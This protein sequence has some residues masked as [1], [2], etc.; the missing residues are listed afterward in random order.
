MLG[1][2]NITKPLRSLGKSDR[3]ERSVVSPPSS[4]SSL[5]SNTSLGSVLPI[6]LLPLS[7]RCG[8]R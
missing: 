7:G 4:V 3:I 8:V 2:K 1:N 5:E 6:I